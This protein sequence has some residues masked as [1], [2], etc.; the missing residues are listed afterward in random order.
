MFDTELL[1]RHKE[2]SVRT[3]DDVPIENGCQTRVVPV[4]FVLAPQMNEATELLRDTVDDFLRFFF[5]GEEC[6][7]V[8][9]FKQDSNVV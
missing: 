9:D 4:H 1:H 6:A 3:M 2:S 5:T 8:F 7:A